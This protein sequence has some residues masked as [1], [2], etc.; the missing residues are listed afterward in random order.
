MRIAHRD[1]EIMA[2]EDLGFLGSHQIGASIKNREMKHEEIIIVVNVYLWALYETV[3]VFNVQRVKMEV[4]LQ[5]IHIFHSG[6]RDMMP[7]QHTETNRIHH[8]F[9]SSP[10]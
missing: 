3:A 8:D 5:K 2:P 7:F 10:F 1:D 9:T 4:I 6:I